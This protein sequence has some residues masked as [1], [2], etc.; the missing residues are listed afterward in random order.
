MQAV[1][2]DAGKP[3][4]LFIALWPEES[5]QHAI[6]CR[7]K[8][9]I[10]PPH[11]ALVKAERLH[12]TLHFLGDV[13]AH[14]LP[15]LRHGLNVPCET[16]TLELNDGEVWPNGVAVLRPDSAPAPL[17]RL[18]AAL[19]RE[20]VALNLPVEARPFRAHVTLARR[21]HGARPPPRAP[22]LHWRID[23]GYVLVRSLPGGAGYAVIGRF[24]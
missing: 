16:F 7:Q 4:R 23:A 13:L 1:F 14:R 24:K 5:L 2:T 21:A 10:W 12:L 17:L 6:A 18:H 15:D 9:W 19:G 22:A 11:A 8:K 20:L 3:L